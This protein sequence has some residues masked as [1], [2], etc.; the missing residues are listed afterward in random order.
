MKQTSL[1]LGLDTKKGWPPELLDVPGKFH[2]RAHSQGLTAPGP[3]AAFWPPQLAAHHASPP[4]WTRS[5]PSGRPRP[6]RP[7]PQAA[8]TGDPGP[9]GLG[10]WAGEAATGDPEV[11]RLAV[12]ANAGRAGLTVP[13]LVAATGRQKT[14]V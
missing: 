6:R 5:P 8:A 2:L 7:R 3:P 4:A 11:A 9:P 1:A 13:E 10:G 12:V 14:W